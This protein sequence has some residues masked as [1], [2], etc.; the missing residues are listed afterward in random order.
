MIFVRGDKDMKKLSQEEKNIIDGI[1]LNLDSIITK[2]NP[3]IGCPPMFQLV[4]VKAK[5]LK[6]FIDISI[7][8]GYFSVKFVQNEMFK[9]FE[10][11]KLA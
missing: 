3:E 7:N 9:I 5:S 6:V 10:L 2:Y 11:Q 1:E 8:K 4:Y